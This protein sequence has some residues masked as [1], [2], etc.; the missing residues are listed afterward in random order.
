MCSL[1]WA[2]FPWWL[3]QSGLG[4]F[5]MVA[6]AVWSGQVSP[7]PLRVSSQCSASWPDGSTRLGLEPT[8]TTSTDMWIYRRC[9]PVST[10]CGHVLFA[11]PHNQPLKPLSVCRLPQAH[12]LLSKAD[13]RPGE[14]ALHRLHPLAQA[15]VQPSTIAPQERT[16]TPRPPS[17]PGPHRP[18]RPPCLNNLS[19]RLW[20]VSTQPLSIPPLPIPHPSTPP[21]TYR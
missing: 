4:R 17:S 6:W 14:G 1:V 7:S 16:P 15:R 13:L 3:V 12:T 18:C 9:A 11:A 2:G 8:V 19:A 21:L 20:V 5:P 10:E